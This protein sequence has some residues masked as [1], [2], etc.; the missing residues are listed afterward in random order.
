[1]VSD[2]KK[3]GRW[4]NFYLIAKIY[5]SEEWWDQLLAWVQQGTLTLEGIAEYE[6]YLSK[7]YPNE[8]ARLY[9][10]NIEEYLKINTGRKYYKNACRYMRRMRKLGATE[11]VKQMIEKFRKE[12]VKRRALMEEL[13]NV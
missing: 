4:T 13:D 1:L 9:K 11:L 3:N 8:L 7:N 2:I 5:I 10:K 12:Y 6:M